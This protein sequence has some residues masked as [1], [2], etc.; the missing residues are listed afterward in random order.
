MS[1]IVTAV[2]KRAKL[3]GLDDFAVEG[4][5]VVDSLLSVS[6]AFEKVNEGA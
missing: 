2:G 4:F 6:L 5:P 3:L 1:L